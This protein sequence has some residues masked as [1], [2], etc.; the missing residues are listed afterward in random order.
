[1]PHN[2]HDTLQ[3]FSHGKYYSLPALGKGYLFIRSVVR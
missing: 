1:M 2:L 3:S